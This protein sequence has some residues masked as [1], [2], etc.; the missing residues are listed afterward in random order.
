M[1]WLCYSTGGGRLARLYK[2]GGPTES[3]DSCRG[4]LIG[5]H[6]AKVCNTFS[7]LS[8]VAIHEEEEERTEVVR[9]VAFGVSE[10][11]GGIN[12]ITDTLLRSGVDIVAASHLA[13]IDAS[14]GGLLH[15]LKVPAHICNMVGR[16]HDRTWF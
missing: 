14:S 1:N 9:Q 8:S 11:H 4:L 10:A 15:Q 12:T 3:T 13:P 6:S 16:L 2:G 7:H 5:D